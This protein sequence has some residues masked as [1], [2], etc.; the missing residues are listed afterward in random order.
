VITFRDSK[1]FMALLYVT[2]DP[3]LRTILAYLAGLLG[4]FTITSTHREGDTGVH[5]TNPLRG[6]DIRHWDLPISPEEICDQVN[7]RWAYDPDR[8][9]MQCAIFH[10]VGK[11]AHL[12]FQ[13]HPKTALRSAAD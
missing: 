9:H 3:K 10:D 13:V 8:P 5:G 11:G 4:R 1:C 2:V 7:S 6:I 12:H